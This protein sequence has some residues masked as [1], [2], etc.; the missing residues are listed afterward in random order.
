MVLGDIAYS[1]S[2]G[3]KNWETFIHENES[4]KISYL[5][6]VQSSINMKIMILPTVSKIYEN[7]FMS[8]FSGWKVI[9]S[10]CD[11]T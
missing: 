9:K 2:Q 7:S 8:K 1:V 5:V 6:H 10:K 4:Y 11:I 3:R